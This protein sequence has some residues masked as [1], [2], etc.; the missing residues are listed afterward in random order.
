[1]AAGRRR[2]GRRERAHGATATGRRAVGSGFFLVAQA[3]MLVAAVVVGLIVAAILLRVFE[4]NP[5]NSIVETVND[6]GKALVGPFDTVFDLDNPKT[7]I[8]VNWGLAALVY[9]VIGSLIARVLR[10]VG[11]KSHPDRV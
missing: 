5:G 11:A 2:L 9:F 6:I 4:A 7:S 10:R 1:M 8:A 3:V